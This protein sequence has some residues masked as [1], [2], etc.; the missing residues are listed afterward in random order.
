MEETFEL[1]KYHA[2]GFHSPLGG[3][4]E[5]AVVGVGGLIK[6]AGDDG[7]FESGSVGVAVV[8]DG[9]VD[10][11]EGDGGVAVGWVKRV[12]GEVDFV[13]VGRVGFSF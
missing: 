11:V 12:R 13:G 8:Q 9:D 2:E 5:C 6:F 3:H 7:G 1:R 4:D 10:G